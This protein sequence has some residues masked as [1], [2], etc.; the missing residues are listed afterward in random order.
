MAFEPGAFAPPMARHVD[1]WIR[2]APLPSLSACMCVLDEIYQSRAGKPHAGVIR[3][4][5]G[6]ADLLEP[7]LAVS[8]QRREHILHYFDYVGLRRG[9]G[10][11]WSGGSRGFL[12]LFTS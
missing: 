6:C 11:T 4:E 1:I 3:I 2:D 10:S 5:V 12:P 9:G 8:P 7:L